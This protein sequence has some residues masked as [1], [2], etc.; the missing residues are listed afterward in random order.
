MFYIH[1]MCTTP[2]STF[3]VRMCKTMTKPMS[4]F[5]RMPPAQVRWSIL[6]FYENKV[7]WFPVQLWPCSIK[8]SLFILLFHFYQIKI[9]TTWEQSQPIPFEILLIHLWYNWQRKC[10]CLLSNLGRYRRSVASYWGSHMLGHVTSKHD[11]TQ[12]QKWH[13]KPL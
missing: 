13:C 2:T 4:L 12:N 9:T 10:P 7:V 5:P 1:T 3:L 11:N 8:K 6:Q